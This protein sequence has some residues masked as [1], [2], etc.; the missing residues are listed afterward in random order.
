ML[1]LL[2]DT[3]LTHLLYS[4]H[5]FRTIHV[6]MET[7]FRQFDTKIGAKIGAKIELITVTLK[8]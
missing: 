2:C 3:D 7:A 1:R 5:P 6:Q 4:A 8:S